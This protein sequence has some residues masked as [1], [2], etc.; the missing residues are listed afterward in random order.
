L[1]V[2]RTADIDGGDAQLVA[3][4]QEYVYRPPPK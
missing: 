4:E 3:R 2:C 1:A